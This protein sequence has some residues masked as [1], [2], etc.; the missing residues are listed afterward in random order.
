MIPMLVT[1]HLRIKKKKNLVKAF[2]LEIHFVAKEAGFNL[3]NRVLY[4]GCKQ[5]EDNLSD[6]D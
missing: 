4:T 3:V 5:L 2:D 6:S 1:T